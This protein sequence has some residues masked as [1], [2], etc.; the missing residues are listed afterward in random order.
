MTARMEVI[1]VSERAT[2]TSAEQVLVTADVV[3]TRTWFSKWQVIAAIDRTTR[4][5]ERIVA[6]VEAIQV[7]VVEG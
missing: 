7:H 3:V 6:A 5:S 1:V 2:R 4:V